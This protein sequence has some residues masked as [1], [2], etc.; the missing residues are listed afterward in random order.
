MARPR[1]KG[2]CHCDGTTVG[3]TTT[4]AISNATTATTA[5][6]VRRS[7]FKR[8]TDHRVA[9]HLTPPDQPRPRNAASRAVSAAVQPSGALMAAQPATN[10]LR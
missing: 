6:W 4:A 1:L 8:L 7:V 3:R 5:N 2:N 9:G 10:A